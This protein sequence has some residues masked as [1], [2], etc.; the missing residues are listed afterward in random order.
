VTPDITGQQED[1]RRIAERAAGHALDAGVSSHST[2][3]VV[4]PR[5]AGGGSRSSRESRC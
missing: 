4:D 2:G 1:T 5:S 3:S